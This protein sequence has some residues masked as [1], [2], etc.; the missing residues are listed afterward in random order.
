MYQHL[1]IGSFLELDLKRS[2]EFFREPEGNIARLN[3]GRSSIYHSLK[4]LKCSTIYMPFYICPE[5]KEFLTRKKIIIKYYNI[6][7]DFTPLLDSNE[8]NS[9]VLIENFFGLFTD[10]QL[11]EKSNKFSNLIIDNCAAFFCPPLSDTYTVYSCRKFF[12]VPDG[13]Y[14][15]GPDAGSGV[16]TYPKDRSS[17]T[18][19]FLL[20]RIEFGCSQV[21]HE[22]VK[23][24]DRINNSD[25]FRMS[26]LTLGLMSSLDFEWI[27]RKRKENFKYASILYHKYNLIHPEDLVQEESIPLFYPLVIKD[28]EL[29]RK[30]QKKKIYTGRRWESVLKDVKEDSFE[31]FLS[32]YMVPIPIDQRYGQAELDYCFEALLNSI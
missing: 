1:E 5:V 29:V 22:K 6:S 8:C 20:K 27:F 26:D 4:L 32:S 16:N 9:A 17:E 31:A 18:A 14:L 12:G 2:G 7:D 3:S 24:E 28:K 25:I 23:N 30:L 10:K 15:I 11:R 21:Y 19:S 13:S